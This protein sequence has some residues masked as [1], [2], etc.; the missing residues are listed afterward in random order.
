[1]KFE[2]LN[3]R[4]RRKLVHT[5]GTYVLDKESDLGMQKQLVKLWIGFNN[6]SVEN[7]LLEIIEK[8][9]KQFWED[10]LKCKYCVLSGFNQN[11]V[12]FYT[13]QKSI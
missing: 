5:S 2:K 9:F 1:M 10:N 7:Y 6:P 8:K 12:R 3:G 11:W 4:N 13:I